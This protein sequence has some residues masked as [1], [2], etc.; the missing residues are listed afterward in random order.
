MGPAFFSL[1]Q[2]SKVVPTNILEPKMTKLSDDTGVMIITPD[3]VLPTT[4]SNKPRL[5]LTIKSAPTVEIKPE[6]VSDDF[7]GS[8]QLLPDYTWHYTHIYLEK[9]YDYLRPIVPPTVTDYV[10]KILIVANYSFLVILIVRFILPFP[11]LL[12]ISLTVVSIYNHQGLIIASYM[13]WDLFS[14]RSGRTKPNPVFQTFTPQTTVWFTEGLSG[15]M[16]VWMFVMIGSIL[17]GAIRSEAIYLII[18][19]LTAMLLATIF[20]TTGKNS[21]LNSLLLV[22]AMFLT[23]IFL[24]GTSD[25]MLQGVINLKDILVNRTNIHNEPPP[26][27]PP[28]ITLWTI[29]ANTFTEP[30]PINILE[31]M[32]LSDQLIDIVGGWHGTIFS[33]LQPLSMSNPYAV[34]RY[35]FSMVMLYSL[36]IG[37]LWGPGITISQACDIQNKVKE[38]RQHG[39]NSI[40]LSR[41]NFAL[42]TNLAI[43]IMNQN[44]HLLILQFL[45]AIVAFFLFKYEKLQWIGLGEL[46]S[47]RA[48][49]D[50]TTIAKG[51]GPAAYR[52]FQALTVVISMLILSMNHISFFVAVATLI[53]LRQWEDDRI[54]CLFL[55]FFGQNISFLAGVFCTRKDTLTSELTARAIPAYATPE[56]GKNSTEFDPKKIL[57]SFIPHAPQLTSGKKSKWIPDTGLQLLHTTADIKPP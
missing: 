6:I 10:L 55:A 20:P 45:S 19:T 2:A 50:D 17:T 37:N 41:W 11:I 35:L 14:S 4:K 8:I 44:F 48:G 32:S 43:T 30:P 53:L 13:A 24:S 28:P 18:A 39:M 56:T 5:K 31:R 27:P 16:F 57:A 29:L 7:I 33:N 46:A 40:L 12:L 47:T 49:R 21:T 22:F 15:I 38:A 54:L 25:L 36:V 9:L 34:M 42:L 1:G 26:P 3:Y 51:E 52:H 23:L